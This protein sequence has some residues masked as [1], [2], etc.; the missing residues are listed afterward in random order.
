MG[1]YVVFFIRER[2]GP[3]LTIKAH[4]SLTLIAYAFASDLTGQT[5][6]KSANKVEDRD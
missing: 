4:I 5:A 2:V 3:I 6:I 1:L